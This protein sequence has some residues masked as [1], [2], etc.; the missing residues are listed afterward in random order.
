MVRWA[1]ILLLSGAVLAAGGVAALSWWTRATIYSEVL[2][3][4][5]V[6]PADLLGFE[7]G[8]L[9]AQSSLATLMVT[10]GRPGPSQ[11]AKFEIRVMRKLGFFF[12]TRE[13][14]LGYFE[15]LPTCTGGALVD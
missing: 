5:C 8:R 14:A 9:D 12:V 13:E 3:N 11:L 6:Q 7:K 15:R 10:R 2:D 4:Y 1:V